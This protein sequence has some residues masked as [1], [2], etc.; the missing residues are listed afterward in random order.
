VD[1][2]ATGEVERV[3]G[4]SEPLAPRTRA[5]LRQAVRDHAHREARRTYPPVLHVGVPG[6]RDASLVLDGAEPG[7]PGLRT[8]VVAALRARAGA[9]PD[10]L[11]WLTRA[12]DLALQDVDA[13]WLS[14]A[15]AAYAE[16]DAELFFVVVNRRGWRDPRS[17]LG[18]TW[19]RVRP[20]RVPN[21]S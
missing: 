9:P 6:D 16:A 13:L 7:D 19:A 8:D 15:R 10:E 14:A 21:G 11:V 4:L 12:G 17:G 1:R 18:R 3:E 5:L 2:S 20:E